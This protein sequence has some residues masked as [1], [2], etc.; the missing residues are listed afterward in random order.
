[1][2][3]D[4]VD[5]ANGTAIDDASPKRSLVLIADSHDD[6]RGMLAILLKAAG[7]D[8]AESNGGGAAISSAR[9]LRPD[10][11][12]LSTNSWGDSL[13]IVSALQDGDGARRPRV[14]VITGHADPAFRQRALMA[15][16]EA[17]LLKPVDVDQLI[18]ELSR[19][20]DAPTLSRVPS[21]LPRD[22]SADARKMVEECCNSIDSA[23]AALEHA[24]AVAARAAKQVER[25]NHFLARLGHRDLPKHVV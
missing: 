7:Y 13:G 24:R 22:S 17:C 9:E 10:V 25:A 2:P 6:S 4:V 14:V 20:T 5:R 16:C 21:R 23:K 19:L 8:T 12:L 18:R 11:V 1:M 15:G 3:R